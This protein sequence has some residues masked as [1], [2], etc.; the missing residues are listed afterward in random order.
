MSFIGKIVNLFTSSVSQKELYDDTV[1]GT[2]F[3]GIDVKARKLASRGMVLLENDGTLPLKESFAL[4]GRTQVDTFYVGYG[5]G[6]DVR[7]PYRV[8]ILNGILNNPDL[9]P[10]L[11]LAQIYQG[12]SKTNPVDHGYWA[13]WPWRYPEM[14]LSDEVVANASKKSNVAVVVI[15]R[16]AGEDRENKL[17]K[18][19]FFLHD[20]EVEMLEK[21]TKYFNKV[22][23]LMN[24]GNVIDFSFLKNYEGKISAL[25]LTWQGGMETGNAVADVLS[26][27]TSPDG[28]LPMTI[29][30]EYADY[31]SADCFGDRDENIYEEDVY[32]GYRYFETFKKDGVLYP[33]GYGL[34]YG[35]FNQSVLAVTNV[36]GQL[37]ISVEVEN[38]GTYTASDTVEIYAQAPS[39]K[40]GKPSK[41]LVGFGKTSPLKSG[42][43][44]IVEVLVPL[45]YLAS[46]DDEGAVKKSSYVLEKGEYT[47]YYGSS[48]RDV[49]PF[50]TFSYDE[51]VVLETLLEAGSPQKSFK[52]IKEIEGKEVLVEAP[53]RSYSLKERIE[54]GLPT[55]SLTYVGDKG[56]KLRDVKNGKITMDDFLAQLSNKELEAISRGDYTMNSKLGAKGNA[57]AI[58]GVTKSLRHKGVPPIITSDGPSGLRLQ[59]V[60]SLL[61]IG[62]LISS[63][64]DTKLAEDLY[65]VI[66]AELVE[67]GSDVLLGPGMNVHRNPLCGRNFEYFSEDP[68]LSGKIGAALVRG[69]QSKGASACPKHYACNNQET[70]R[71]RNDS[72]LSERALR[73]IYLKGFEI[74]IKESQP[75][76]VMTSYNK[77]NGVW[78]HYNY[79]LCTTVLRNEW[80]FKGMVMTDWWMQSSVSQEFPLLKD[81]AYR[82]RAQVDVLMPGGAR[83]PFAFRIPDGTLL[84]SL[85]KE[86]GITRGELL[87]T[88][89]NVLKLAL[90]ST[91][92][93]R[94]EN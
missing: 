87:R 83:P 41:V 53:T 29:A 51:D 17:E 31:P 85:G 61:P 71:V 67:R 55:R 63:T 40:L 62:T 81:Q 5:S 74:C 11:E 90:K 21:V 69:I 12:Y 44:E 68:V 22:V 26:G 18:G 49:N 16:A 65:S 73:E 37:S 78:G 28:K 59:A 91:A 75:N 66:G 52:R 2:A 42:E 4:F 48:V 36:N 24:I 56:Y 9:K 93:K 58:G 94:L 38:V 27:A 80:G 8:S 46:Y 23:L 84:A 45:Y 82:V 13:H 30:K 34:G 77:I 50:H 1:R 60:C 57:G 7:A 15:G 86:S 19:S 88:A 79:D 6:G 39:G 3:N 89:E 25:L 72:V 54:A 43:K 64:W 47:L 35:K 14:P 33:F 76:T 10:D 32:V 20:E 92:F 70:N